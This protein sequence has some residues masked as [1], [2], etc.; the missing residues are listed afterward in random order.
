VGFPTSTI[1]RAALKSVTYAYRP[2]TNTEIGDVPTDT[3]PTCE[4]ADGFDTSIIE[5][6][7]EALLAVYAYR[8]ET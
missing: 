3:R 2:E 5:I 1:E 7:F 6:V 8:P 4:G